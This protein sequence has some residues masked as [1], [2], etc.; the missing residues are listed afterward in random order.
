MKR[1]KILVADDH[2]QVRE[3]LQKLLDREFEVISCVGDGRALLKAAVE[4]KP[5]VVVVD[6]GL[7]LMNGLEAGRALKKLM[8]EVKLVYLTMNADPDIATEAS[9]I[10]AS[11]YLLKSLMGQELVQVIRRATHTD[12]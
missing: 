6:V 8:P 7:P 10:G 3:A 9:R 4:L 1:L 11:G 2:P 5:D 12:S